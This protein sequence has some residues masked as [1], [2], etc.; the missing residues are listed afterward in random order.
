MSLRSILILLLV[1]LLLPRLASAWNDTGHMTIA[2]IAYRQLDDAQRQK[3]GQ[4]LKSHPHYDLYLASDR[5]DGVSE[6]EWAFL[7]AANWPDF[8][9]PSRPRSAEG[10]KDKQITRYHHSDW[11]YIDLPVV[12]PAERKTIDTTKLPPPREPNVLT[13]IEANEKL[14]TAADTKPEDRA[15]ALSWVEHL[16]GDVHQ[17]LHS[18]SEYSNAFPG[19][20]RGGNAQAVRADGAVINIHAFWDEALGTTDSFFEIDF[21]ARDI[22]TDPALAPSNLAELELD[23]K[24]ADWARESRDA[25]MG[26]VYLNG[27]LRSVRSEAYNAR[28]VVDEQ[29]PALPASYTPNAHALAKRRVALAGYRLAAALKELLAK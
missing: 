22:T 13:E 2:L 27:R 20:D 19:G 5:P 21:L 16:I 4:I 14:L 26:M 9:R 24:P 18:V 12:P 8:V 11:H 15:V 23:K 6:E 1:T 28:E 7:R 17:P 3:I 25:A 10:P 29:V